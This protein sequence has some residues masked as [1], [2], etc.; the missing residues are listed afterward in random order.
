MADYIPLFSRNA[1]KHSPFFHEKRFPIFRKTT[2]GNSAGIFTVRLYAWL[3]FNDAINALA[4][5]PANT[6][7][8][9]SRIL[10][11]RAL[12]CFFRG[13]IKSPRLIL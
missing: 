4:A 11:A 9:C 13:I 5:A 8:R 6:N 12:T 1:K 2:T 7:R 3:A 10:N